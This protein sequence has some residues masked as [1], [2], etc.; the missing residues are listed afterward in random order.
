MTEA[1]ILIPENIDFKKVSDEIV[2]KAFNIAIEKKKKEIKKEL[3]RTETKITRFE[4][5]YNASL[6]EFERKM[7]DSIKEHNDWMDWSF[8]VE[9]RKQLLNDLQTFKDN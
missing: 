7:D 3:K 2:Y 6:E 5:K 9:N 1:T 8:L 4:K